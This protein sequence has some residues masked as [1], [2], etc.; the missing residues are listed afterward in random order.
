M[1]SPL[2]GKRIVVTG[3]AGFLG[4]AVCQRLNALGASEVLIPRRAE[5][6]LTTEKLL[7]VYIKKCARKLCCTLPPK[8][9]E[10]AQT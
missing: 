1:A 6:D 3:G 7:I 8:L 2:Q 10:L 5:F 4:R 9:V